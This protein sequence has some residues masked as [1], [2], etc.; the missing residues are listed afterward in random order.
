MPL[1]VVWRMTYSPLI[2]HPMEVFIKLSLEQPRLLAYPFHYCS[3]EQFCTLYHASRSRTELFPCADLEPVSLIFPNCKRLSLACTLGNTDWTI[4][5]GF[6]LIFQV[7]YSKK[8]EQF[9][10]K[11][12]KIDLQT[13]HFYFAT[14]CHLN[15]LAIT[16]YLDKVTPSSLLLYFTLIKDLKV[17]R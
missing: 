15:L 8:F 9:W 17:F 7:A 14:V 13:W 16:K 10:Y 2:R 6:S 5:S 1:L 12:Y 3:K 4:F 11:Y